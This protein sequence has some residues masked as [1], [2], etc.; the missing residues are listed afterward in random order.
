MSQVPRDFVIW[1]GSGHTKVLAEIVTASGG[2][3][4]AL[5]DNDSTR[6]SPLAGVP[7]HYGR[8]EFE[9]WIAGQRNPQEISAISAIG[10][11][12]GQDRI[13]YLSLFKRFGLLTPSLVHETAH[14]SSEA[15][16]GENSHILAMS[17][18]GAGAI[19]GEAVIVNTKASVDHECE[20]S[21]GVH[22][23][24]GATLCGCV[25][26]G[27]FSFVGAGAIILPRV[28]IGSNVTVGAGSVVIR[29]LPDNVVAVG[30]P[31]RII[32]GKI[33]ASYRGESS[34]GS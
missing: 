27:P 17:V 25:R 34:N 26:I 5:F 30:N 7:L 18:V 23:G 29:N 2:R 15:V 16:I 28:R 24:P 3:V 11:G 22:I 9:R 4:V 12:R 1:G 33:Y 6:S 21:R 14:M 13:D 10:G 20:I 31:A 19:M 32:K 8:D